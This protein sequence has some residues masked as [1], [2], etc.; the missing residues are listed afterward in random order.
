MQVNEPRR[1]G[2]PLV[3]PALLPPRILL[4][5]DD[6]E[7]RAL[8]SDDLR[9]AGYG[10]VECAD[11]AAL[12]LRLESTSRTEGM[13]V[14]LVIADVRMP[15]MTGLEALERL[16]DVDP[17]LPYIIVTAFGS[18]ETRLAAGRLGA[19]AVLD[20]PFEIDDLLLLVDD[21]IGARSREPC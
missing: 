8:V 7:M 11:G 21:A 2:D 16:R 12:L 20:K 9:R 4:A 15:G 19:I 13:G 1:A 18:A 14:D 6:R 10:V 17:F 5:E 3:D